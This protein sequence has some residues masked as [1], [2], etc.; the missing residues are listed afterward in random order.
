MAEP[1]NITNRMAD[2]MLALGEAKIA[3]VQPTRIQ[4]QKFVY[5]CDVLGQVVGT[6]KPKEGHKTY[7]NGPYDPAIQNAVDCL[8]F[9]GFVQITGVWKI[10]GGATGTKYALAEPGRQFL[11]RLRAAREFTRKFQVAGLVGV[12]L[13]KLGWGRIVALA[14]AEPTFVATRSSGWGSQLLAEDGLSV[15][16]AFVLAIMRRTVG[17]I[18]PD[19]DPAPEWVAD[20]FFA[21]LDDYDR[22]CGLANGGVTQK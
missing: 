20:R 11:T 19:F 6:L 5:L 15:S 14:Y 1:E 22:T 16:T 9:R 21:Y 2:V 17:A 7:R 3:Q 18:Y 13:H 10:A 8:A 12:E 4:L